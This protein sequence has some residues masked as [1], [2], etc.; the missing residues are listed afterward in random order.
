MNFSQTLM[1]VCI[2]LPLAAAPVVYFLQ[3]RNEQAGHLLTSAVCLVVLC[4]AA[5]LLRDDRTMLYLPHV[6]LVGLSFS[7]VGFKSIFGLLCAYLFFMSS[8]AN[9]AYFRGTARVPRYTTFL[10]LT[11]SG[12]MGVFYAGDLFTLYIFF[13]IM[14]LASWVWV[15][16]TETPGAQRAADTY[17]AMAMIGGLTMLYGLFIL[18]HRFGTLSLPELQILSHSLE[19][20]SSLYLPALCLLIGFGI[21]AGMFPFHVWLPKAHPVAP[22]PASALLSGILTKSGIFGILLIVVCLLWGNAP[23]MLLVMALGVIT[24][25]LGAV[26]AIFSVDLKRTLACSSLSQIGFL[27]VGIAMLTMGAETDLAAAGIMSHAV[28]HALTKLVLF[29]SAG[30]LYKNTHTLN[31]NELQG[32]GRKRL[33]LMLCFAIGGLSIAGVPGFGGYVSKT[34]L[35]E[36]LVHQMHFQT[37]F[38][39]HVGKGAEVLFLCSGG[40]TLAYMGKLFYKIFIQKPVHPHTIHIDKGSLTAIV[41]T[42]AAL[43]LMGLFPH[44]TYGSMN[45]Y[46]AHSLGSFPVEVHYFA[47]VNLQGALI[48]LTIGLAVYFLVVRLLLTDRKTGLY[49]HIRGPIDLEDHVYRPLLNGVAF[50]GAFFGRVLY[51]L[52][53]W[54]TAAIRWLLRL[55]NARRVIPGE[56]SQF[57]RYGQRDA[58]PNAI[59]QT[60]QFELLLFGIGVVVMLLYL[61]ITL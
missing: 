29:V 47:W 50:L 15:A 14:S 36:S 40:L 8:L 34:L 53:S 12:I 18:Y 56:D 49:R 23:F 10:L 24:M 2:L 45:A 11:L 19:D 1:L 25:V 52:T 48:S 9:P 32:A 42:A 13:E 28:N 39:L 58:Q 37:G 22:A 55:G 46:T 26:L 3:R 43:L 44:S 51:S 27:L 57:G 41:P 61:L 30:V 21:K 31:L 16:H 7:A 5:I 4:A 33:P 17:L 6:F 59:R 60:L 35:H 20:P 54:T 38:L